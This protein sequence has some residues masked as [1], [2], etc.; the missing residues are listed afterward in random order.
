MPLSPCLGTFC[1]F[2]G[3]DFEPIALKELRGKETDFPKDLEKL[4]SS[5]YS[6]DYKVTLKDCLNKINYFRF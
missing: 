1:I 5:I 4:F 3:V 6:M 2:Q